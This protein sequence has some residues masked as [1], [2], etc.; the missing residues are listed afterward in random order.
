MFASNV[1]SGSNSGN[2]RNNTK[3]YKHIFLCMPPQKPHV[4]GVLTAPCRKN[5]RTL[6]HL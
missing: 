1:N 5:N 4:H 2:T 3:P 6:P